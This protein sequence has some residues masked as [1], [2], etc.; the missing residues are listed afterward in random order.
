MKL[1]TILLLSF[2]TIGSAQESKR[3]D[4]KEGN[5]VAEIS[6]EEETV[7]W[8]FADNLIF[9]DVKVLET[10]GVWA[11]IEYSHSRPRPRMLPSD[12]PDAE[13]PQAPRKKVWVNTIHV[14]Q[15]Q[16]AAKSNSQNL[17]RRRQQRT[18]F[19]PVDNLFVFALSA[20]S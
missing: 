13:L 7:H 19:Q 16:P 8:Y 17:Y 11:K 5:L 20:F 1:I 3:T 6:K 10:R 12:G 2:A 4:A 18:T 15:I 9:T 14:I